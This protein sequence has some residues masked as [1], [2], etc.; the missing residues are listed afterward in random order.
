MLDNETVDI[1]QIKDIKDDVEYYIDNCQDPDFTENEMI[2]DDIDGLEEML[3]DVSIFF[4]WGHT[5]TMWTIFW[6]FLTP[7]PP[8]GPSMDF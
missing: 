1:N 4:I 8:C 6:P 7:L 2:Y 3:L 5:Q